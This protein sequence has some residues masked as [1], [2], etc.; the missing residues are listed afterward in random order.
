MSQT[1]LPRTHVAATWTI[2]VL[3]IVAAVVALGFPSRARIYPLSASVAGILLS[4]LSLRLAR[5]T[6][7]SP[8][9]ETE[10]LPW[11][12]A[13][14]YFAAMLGYLLLTFVIG[15]VTASAILLVVALRRNAKTGW[16]AAIASGVGAVVF[17][18]GLSAWLG[19]R[20]PTALV[21]LAGLLGIV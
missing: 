2:V 4:F 19:L 9:S 6:T 15:L 18:A 12:R 7:A 11:R 13:A 16:L 8:E 17:L 20:W 5:R 21:D 10:E 3:L 14:P 1:R